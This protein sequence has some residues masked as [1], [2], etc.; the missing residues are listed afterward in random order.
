[1]PALGWDPLSGR[2]WLGVL[3]GVLGVVVTLSDRL[4]RP[5]SLTA[6]VWT[7]IGLGGLAG[8]SLLQGR[9]LGRGGP[10]A[11]TAVQ[12][13]AGAVTTAFWAPFDGSLRI[14][15]TA[16]ALTSF[17]WL[18]LVAGVAGPLL[19]LALIGRHGPTRGTSLLFLVPSF[20]AFFGWLLLGERVGAVA[21]L[22]LAIAGFGLWLGRRPARRR[23]PRR[24]PV[25]AGAGVRRARSPCSADPRRVAGMDLTL[26]DEEREIREWVRTFVTKELMPLEPE[27]LERER[28]GE[29]GITLDEVSAMQDKARESGF[30][31]IQ[32]PEEYGGMGLGAVMHALIEAELGRTFVP[33]KF[34]GDAD[35]I[36]FEANDEQRETLPASHDRGHAPQ[37]L[38]D[39]RAGCRVRRAEHPHD[40]RTRR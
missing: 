8:G 31:G 9:L 36:L 17:G 40:R 28:R 2:Q 3:L 7:V 4:G 5:P 16:S 37:L 35:N 18:A 20:T 12:V 26:S 32:T 10:T 6:L 30:F 33:F 21:L 24:L 1:M 39:H 13:A 19:L 27:V 15:E 11:L 14:P 22:G 34:G 38:R 25:P 23:Q 29:A